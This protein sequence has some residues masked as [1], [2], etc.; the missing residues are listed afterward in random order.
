[1]FKRKQ[2]KIRK[3]VLN[4]NNINTA[5]NRAKEHLM[6]FGMRYG[7]FEDFGIEYYRAIEDKYI[8]ICDYSF[9]MQEN[10]RALANFGQWCTSYLP[11]NRRF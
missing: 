7:I 4:T 6:Y 1:M 11:A 9:E 2:I 5:I 10:R 8:D 3:S